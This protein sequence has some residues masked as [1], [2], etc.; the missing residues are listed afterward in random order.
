MLCQ[1]NPPERCSGSMQAVQGFV[2]VE[3]EWIYRE[4]MSIRGRTV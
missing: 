1:L 4:Y 3:Y 2:V